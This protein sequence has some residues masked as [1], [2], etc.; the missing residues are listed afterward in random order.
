[1]SMHQIICVERKAATFSHAVCGF[2]AVCLITGY[3]GVLWWNVLVINLF[4]A[5]YQLPKPEGVANRVFHACC[6]LFIWPFNITMIFLIAGFGIVSDGLLTCAPDTTVWDGWMADAFFFIP[7]SLFMIFGF[8]LLTLVVLRILWVL[9]SKTLV[10]GASIRMIIYLGYGYLETTY[11]LTFHFENRIRNNAITDTY[12]RYLT[13]L[14]NTLP[15]LRDSQCH[16]DGDHVHFSEIVV[17]LILGALAPWVAFWMLMTKTSM[18]AHWI[19]AFRVYI[20][21]QKEVKNPFEEVKRRQTVSRVSQRMTRST[22]ASTSSSSG[23][24]SSTGFTMEMPE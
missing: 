4:L 3:S 19:Y 18:W 23:T 15:W 14:A 21:R 9:R 24:Q 5:A 13:C 1:M 6:H 22:G 8:S 16:I 7:F 10:K 2:Q 11:F 12:T 17:A 20:L